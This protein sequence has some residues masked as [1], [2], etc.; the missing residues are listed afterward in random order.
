MRR[1][2]FRINS[3]RLTGAA[4]AVAAGL[5]A[6]Q[7]AEAAVTVQNFD[8]PLEAAP[9]LDIDLGN[10]T[11]REFRLG[12]A[13]DGEFDDLGIKADSFAG[14]IHGNPPETWPGMAGVIMENNDAANLALGTLIGPAD[15]Y[16]SPFLT[17][18]NGH[19]NDTEG[20]PR[21]NFND[22]SGFIG[23]QFELN[24]N[25][26]YGYVGYEGDAGLGGDG[27]VFTIGWEDMPD[28]A[29]RAGNVPPGL[30][31]D[32]DGDNDVDGNDFLVWQRGLGTT[33]DAADLTAWQMEF[34][35]TAAAASAAGV[36]EPT[37]LALL[38]AGAAGLPLYRRRQRS[39]QVK[40]G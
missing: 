9:G 10:D 2:P 36:P 1:G 26:H 11:V 6:G 20:I 19:T 24:A 39:E 23:V 16:V 28:T 4:G 21:G 8:P 12:V 22:A 33:H 29:L 15:T 3:R 38:A 5:G 37:S 13:I 34:G 27:R 40:R 18:L 35:Q 14:T 31:A 30:T 32:F 25:T 7:S 17:R